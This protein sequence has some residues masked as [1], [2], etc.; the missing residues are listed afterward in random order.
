MTNFRVTLDD[1]ELAEAVE[2]LEA[3][4]AADAVRIVLERYF[5]AVDVE[6]E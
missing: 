6:Q 3:R 4:D 1:I 5:V 2:R